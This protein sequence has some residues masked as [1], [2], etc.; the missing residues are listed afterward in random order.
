MTNVQT[1]IIQ[2][3]TAKSQLYPWMETFFITDKEIIDLTHTTLSPKKINKQLR[4]LKPIFTKHESQ[5]YQG[6]R[7]ITWA[8]NSWELQKQ[9]K[10]RR[11][12]NNPQ[13]MQEALIEYFNH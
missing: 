4:Q 8:F 12:Q 2:A 3:I 13:F 11:N 5:K 10:T 7:T 1:T 6:K 9:V